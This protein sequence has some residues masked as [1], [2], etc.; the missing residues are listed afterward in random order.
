MML[1]ASERARPCRGKQ[2]TLGRSMKGF[3]WAGNRHDQ[4]SVLF[5]NLIC[6]Y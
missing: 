1:E 5:L 2:V 6:F 3:I 4:V